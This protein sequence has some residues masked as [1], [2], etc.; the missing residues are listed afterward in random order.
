MRCVLHTKLC[1]RK[2]H[3]DDCISISKLRMIVDIVGVGLMSN[4]CTIPINLGSINGNY[5]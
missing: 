5:A 3:M 4:L 1:V 2:S